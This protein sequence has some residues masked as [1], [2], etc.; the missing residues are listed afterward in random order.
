MRRTVAE[1]LAPTGVDGADGVRVGDVFV[2]TTYSAHDDEPPIPAGHWRRACAALLALPDA[3]GY[4][5]ATTWLRRADNNG[6][7]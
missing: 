1:S 5:R 7:G 4:V 6:E 2:T 3:A